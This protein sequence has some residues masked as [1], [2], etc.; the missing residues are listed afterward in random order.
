MIILYNLLLVLTLPVWA[1]WMAVRARRRK[2]PVEW[3]ERQ[4]SYPFVLGR[5]K[6]R[7]WVHAVSVGEFMACQPLLHALRE[8]EP[9]PEVVVSTTT[10]S[11][12]GEAEKHKG[13][14]FD[15]LVYFPIDVPRFCLK[16]LLSVKPTVIVMM[17]TEIWPNFLWTAHQ[18]GI[19]ALVANGRISDKTHS[20]G[21]IARWVYRPVLRTVDAVLAQSDTDRDRFLALGARQAESV[22]NTKFDQALGGM[23]ATSRDWLCELGTP[24]GCPVIVV[25][26][27]RSEAEEALVADALADP[28]IEGCAVVWAPRH[29]E[30]APEVARQLERIG[31][32]PT[33]RSQGGKGRTVVLDTYGE[34][35][36]VYT[37]AD[38]VVVGGG[39]DTLGG[40][41]I[42]QPMAHGKPVVHGPN[43][44]NFRDIARLAQEAGA[45]VT[46]EPNPSELA[47]LLADLLTDPSRRAQIG[48][49]GRALVER[50]RGASERIA[51]RVATYFDAP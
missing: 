45:A 26:S 12:H 10:S 35:A 32:E 21:W 7:V 20:R 51:T 4:G 25:G 5:S 46:C 2:E 19:P 31:R 11:G 30:R 50:H 27:T 17:E 8:I 37:I 18:M 24:E 16:A 38:V 39:F 14:L 42:L 1:T 48:S 47:Q 9:N 15:R 33:L 13:K 44:S 28:R 6:R 34:L 49:A 3:A 23:R 22:G 40:Q 41:D 29:I 36:Q 43:M